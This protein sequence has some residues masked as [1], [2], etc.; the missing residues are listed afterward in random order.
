[1]RT[2]QSRTLDLRT[3][4]KSLDEQLR[5]ANARI[6]ELDALLR[7][8]SDEVEKEKHERRLDEEHWH[9][10]S[11]QRLIKMTNSIATRL[12]HEIREAKLCLEG[13]SPN[14]PWALDRLAQM[15]EALAKL[16]ET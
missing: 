15:E 12:S 3:S 2:E 4:V 9:T 10:R 6:A 16:R 11:E 14:L 5:G 7:Q 8:K 1:L 13:D